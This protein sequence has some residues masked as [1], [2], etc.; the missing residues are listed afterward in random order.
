MMNMYHARRQVELQRA[1]AL[2][3]AERRPV[4]RE[5]RRGGT[6][7]ASAEARPMTRPIVG[8]GYRPA[9]VARPRPAG[10]PRA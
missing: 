10:S 2:A 5:A 3:W 4:A 1:E 8:G 9:D 7:S 6:S